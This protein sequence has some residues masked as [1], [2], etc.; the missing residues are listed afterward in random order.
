MTLITS[1]AD[2][3]QLLPASVLESISPMQWQALVLGLRHPALPA[4]AS[5]HRHVSPWSCAGVKFFD[6]VTVTDP[7]SAAKAYLFSVED[8]EHCACFNIGEG[9]DGSPLISWSDL[10]ALYQLPDGSKW[11]EHGSLYDIEDLVGHA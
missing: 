5:L 6:E 8:R 1:L 7:D 2:I 9:A 11:A 10:V 4:I 3:T